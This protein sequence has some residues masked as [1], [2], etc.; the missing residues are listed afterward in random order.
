M[1]SN[2]SRRLLCLS[3]EL[4]FE[5]RHC[6]SGALAP[7]CPGLWSYRVDVRLRCGF[8][9]TGYF[10]TYSPFWDCSYTVC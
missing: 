1:R 3:G 2:D 8:A 4:G 5:P 6:A 9:G 10:S 7:N